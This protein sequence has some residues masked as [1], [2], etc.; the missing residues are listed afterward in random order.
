MATHQRDERNAGITQGAST[1]P[2][3]GDPG[4]TDH[5]TGSTLAAENAANDRP[6]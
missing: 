3:S 6:S 2:D 1:A 4:D 5:P